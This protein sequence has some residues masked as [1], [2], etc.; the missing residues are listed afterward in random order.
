MIEVVKDVVK[1]KTMIG[2]L[3]FILSVSYVGASTNN[4]LRADNKDINFAYITN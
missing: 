2:V 3:I 4:N 1:S